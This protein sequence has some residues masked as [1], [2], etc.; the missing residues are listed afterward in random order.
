MQG[1][2]KLLVTEKLQGKLRN[3]IF[4]CLVCTHIGLCSRAQMFQSQLGLSSLFCIL[5]V[6]CA[7]EYLS[8]ILLHSVFG[9]CPKVTTLKFPFK[10][11]GQPL[12]W[13]GCCQNS[14]TDA[15][16]CCAMSSEWCC[17]SRYETRG[18]WFAEELH[19]FATFAH[20]WVIW[21][22]NLFWFDGDSQS[23][24]TSNV[25]WRY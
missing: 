12:F 6:R 8:W 15:Q 7:P 20:R 5:L 24:L 2:F 3:Q 17:P 14:E 18:I 25:F 11:E 13:K 19:L 10:Q 16:C 4:M 9:N 23:H 1:I 21:C 22:R